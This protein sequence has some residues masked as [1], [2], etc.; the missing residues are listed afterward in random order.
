MPIYLGNKKLT[1]GYF[2]TVPL[3]KTMFGNDTVC[4]S[5]SKP[6]PEFPAPT[7]NTRFSMMI[8][9]STDLMPDWI[10][11][12]LGLTSL[13]ESSNVSGTV[14]WSLAPKG[15][16][17]AGNFDFEL[18]CNL[19]VTEFKFARNKSSILNIQ[20]AKTVNVN[21]ATIGCKYY[22]A[23]NQLPNLKTFQVLPAAGQP[24]LNVCRMFWDNKNLEYVDLPK[25]FFGTTPIDHERMFMDTPKLKF[26]SYLDTRHTITR[27]GMFQNSNPLRPSADEREAL[28]GAWGS[29]F[30]F[31]TCRMS[32]N[33]SWKKSDKTKYLMWQ[34]DF[35][36][37]EYGGNHHSS[38]VE[39]Y[40]YSSEDG[41]EQLAASRHEL[42]HF[43]SNQSIPKYPSS[44]LIDRD[45]STYYLSY[46]WGNGHYGWTYKVP[47]AFDSFRLRSY[48]HTH[49]N[50]GE[51]AGH[52]MGRDFIVMARNSPNDP[53]VTLFTHRV[54][55]AGN[56]GNWENDE[57]RTILV[58]D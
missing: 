16:D 11:P 33:D 54:M 58:P 13:V 56:Y 8:K 23:F 37:K 57:N 1:C 2:G 26:I 20:V 35:G 52:A 18:R 9:S 21:G 15:T 34:I 43:E 29:R 51:T 44:N 48:G 6:F 22:Y 53:W 45:L 12:N 4:T 10:N 55:D 40:A 25:S 39:I 32:S 42:S 38:A 24:A 17:T 46:H 50:A 47:Q 5:C 14:G 19:T 3:A 7:S 36:N 49:T 27:V 30:Q 41:N 28:F 31:D